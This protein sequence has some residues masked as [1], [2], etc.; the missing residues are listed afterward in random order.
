M[1]R[2]KFKYN[3]DTHPISFRVSNTITDSGTEIRDKLAEL[4]VKLAQG[5]S[6]SK[7]EI[8]YANEVLFP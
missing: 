3:A 7:T 1:A 6:V 5:N 2:R 4:F 8:D